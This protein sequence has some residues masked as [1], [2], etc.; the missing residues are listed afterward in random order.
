VK[1]SKI[2]NVGCASADHLPTSGVLTFT[3][4]SG[5][6]AHHLTVS[7]RGMQRT[8]TGKV[9]L[10]EETEGGG[11]TGFAHLTVGSHHQQDQSTS[12]PPTAEAIRV[13]TLAVPLHL[14]RTSLRLAHVMELGLLESREWRERERSERERERR[15]RRRR[16][17]RKKGEITQPT[18]YLDIVRVSGADPQVR[19][20]RRGSLS[21]SLPGWSVSCT[22]ALAVDVLYG[23]M[24]HL[25]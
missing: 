24:T 5:E 22:L 23:S 3:P 9:L 10:H 18:P 21:P 6:F 25:M 15:R 20:H 13:K 12:T 16:R 8:H 2:S 17:R 4:H 11:L 7:E 19:V 14:H 1:D